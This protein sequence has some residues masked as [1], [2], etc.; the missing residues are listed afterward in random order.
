MWC[1][2]CYVA[3][4]DDDFYVQVAEDDAG[5][6]WK[7]RG[8]DEL[9][10]MHGRDGDHLM[11]PFQCDTCVFRILNGRNPVD[12]PS[13]NRLMCFIR[14][15]NLD[16]MW[17]RETSTVVANA[18]NLRKGLELLNGLNV[19]L[20][21]YPPLGP[22]PLTDTQGYLVALQ[23]LAHSRASGRYGPYT[24]FETIRK[25]R[26]AFSNV[27][28]ASASGAGEVT[29]F[30]GDDRRYSAVTRCPTQS[31][32]FSRF[33]LGC[34]KRMG[35]D[36]RPDL[37]M[38]IG[39]LH[40][41]IEELVI[42]GSEQT[43]E[44]RM[45]LIISVIAYSTICF[46]AS[47]RG[48]EGFYV[49]LHGLRLHIN[50][51][52]CVTGDGKIPHVVVPLLGRFKNEVGERHHL[53][54][55]ASKTATELEPRRWIEALIRV[56]EAEGRINGPAFVA[57]DGCV[58]DSSVYQAVIVEALIRVQAKRSDLIGKEIDVSEAYGV[59]RSFRRGS[60]THA[61]NQKVSESDVTATNR[62]RTV[63]MARGTK[64][65]LG[66]RDHYSE[67]SQMVATLVRYSA[68]L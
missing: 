39:V 3:H 10:F 19:D 17:S 56:R 46:C 26:G 33:A 32:W 59:S 40:A 9:R 63:E 15:I 12:R 52:R 4:P 34:K 51:G 44:E 48:H 27:Y 67:V 25:L 58:E 62:W 42:L 1:G 37:A 8:E 20:I 6:A 65:S 47:L 29:A 21:G 43:S 55:L 41:L 68:A 61:G 16:S 66:M 36:V 11:S 45:R 57:S 23:M 50:K 5:Y 7:R 14:R 13:D 24:Q 2:K 35:Q 49:D 64:P 18:G 30:G 38:S 31:R 22:F 54:F 28:H 53:I 60:V